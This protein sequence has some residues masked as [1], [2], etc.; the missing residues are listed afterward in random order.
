MQK[1]RKSEGVWMGVRVCGWGG[2]RVCGWEGDNVPLSSSPLAEFS[3]GGLNTRT[4]VTMTTTS[5][6]PHPHTH[7]TARTIL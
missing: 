5:H 7:T 4:L 1:E 3:A 6:T 2:V